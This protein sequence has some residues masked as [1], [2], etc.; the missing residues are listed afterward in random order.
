MSELLGAPRVLTRPDSLLRESLKRE[1]SRLPHLRCNKITIMHSYRRAIVPSRSVAGR[2]MLRNTAQTQQVMVF[3][4]P[5]LGE[6]A[7]E[8]MLPHQRQM[9][10]ESNHCIKSADK[11]L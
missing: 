4:K 2:R 11:N 10:L 9:A 8:L 5:S 6:M 7:E 3:A 1:T